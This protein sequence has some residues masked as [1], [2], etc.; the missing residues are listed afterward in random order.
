MVSVLRISI[1]FLNLLMSVA[2]IEEKEKSELTFT[3]IHIQCYVV[4]YIYEYGAAWNGGM[5]LI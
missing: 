3:S 5:V 1:H 2:L 4:F